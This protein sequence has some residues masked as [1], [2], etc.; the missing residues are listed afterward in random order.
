MY[1]LHLTL[2]K[3]ESARAYN[4][5]FVVKNE[6]V[7]KVTG[8]HIHFKSSNVLKTVLD[9]VSETTVH[10]HEVHVP[11]GHL[12]AAA[13]MTLGVCQG[14]SSIASFISRDVIYASRAYATMSSVRLSVMEV[15]W[16]VVHAGKGGAII[17]HY[18][19]HC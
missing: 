7:L 14:H 1:I 10:K 12:I 6:G 5:S 17:S 13:V 18:T 16:V 8:S 2:I 15:H 19:S 3:K 9:K 4:L 11:Y